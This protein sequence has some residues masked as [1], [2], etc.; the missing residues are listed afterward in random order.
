MA[1]SSVRSAGTYGAINRQNQNQLAAY[2]ERLSS[3]RRI[4]KA[5]DDAAGLM[6]AKKLESLIRGSNKATDNADTMQNA[7]NVADG[8][9]GSATES[10]NRMREL[11]VQSANGVYTDEDRAAMQMEV[12]QLTEHIDKMSSSVE[13]N[14]QKLL[15]GSFRNK[16]AGENP[17]GSG[18]QIS[19]G[20][21]SAKGL[22]IDNYDISSGTGMMSA[23][24]SALEKIGFDRSKIGAQYNGL[25]SAA[26]YNNINAENLEAGRSRIEDM[27]MNKG[28]LELVKE[29]AKQQ[30]SMSVQKFQMQMAGMQLT[31]LV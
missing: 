2:Q 7:L 9:L 26:N 23:M 20:D 25:E 28:V 6:T 8:A 5:A 3:G 12:S 21:V 27:D 22:G 29:K 14:K 19:V 24:D 10:L 13:F 18:Q 16:I 4:N 15:D 11:N 1:I 31:L 17:D 30:Y